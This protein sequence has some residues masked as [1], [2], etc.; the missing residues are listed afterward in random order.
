[1]VDLLLSEV[2]GDNHHHVI[3][4][5]SSWL[6]CSSSRYCTAVTIYR[7][8]VCHAS[9]LTDFITPFLRLHQIR[10]AGRPFL[11][12]PSSS[13]LAPSQ[14]P[15][16]LAAARRAAE[17]SE[18]ASS[19]YTSLGWSL[20]SKLHLS[21]LATWRTSCRLGMLGSGRNGQRYLASGRSA[22][23]RTKQNE[24]ASSLRVLCAACAR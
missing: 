8:Q 2:C 5:S 20:R 14:P 22:S 9:L 3:I 18:T 23:N 1:M 4:V 12:S 17:R 10:P 16:P 6:I 11:R 19:S 21:H 24:A 15:R 13:T 7:D